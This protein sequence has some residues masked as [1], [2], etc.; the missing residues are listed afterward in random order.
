MN[1]HYLSQTNGFLSIL[2]FIRFGLSEANR[3][4]LY[5]GHGS[6][7][8][9]D[10]I[11]ALILGSL[12][13]DLDIDDRFL[14]ARLNKEEQKHLSKQLYQ[15]I[16]NRIPVAYLIH[17]SFFCGLPFYVDERVLI[18]RSPI[19]ELIEAEFSPWIKKEH[20]RRILDL[21]TGSG[22]IAIALAHQF[23][24]ASVLGSDLSA[25]ALMVAQKNKEAHLLDDKLTLIQSDC[26]QSI[27]K[28]QYDLIVSNPPYVSEDEFNDLPL[29]YTH[30][31]QLG[32]KAGDDGLSIV[33]IIL[34][35]AKSYL[36]PHGIL[37][38]EVGNAEEALINAFP[39]MP[40][41]WLEFERGGSGVFLLT[42]EDLDRNI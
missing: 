41:I 22:C 32:L 30:E 9:F 17:K 29:E 14:S 40:F 21:G 23:P 2:D 3:H 10:E 18:P 26:F 5:Y 38:V 27:P 8:A 16:Q 33:K 1:D 39:E 7:T 6:D 13:L 20:V 37:V 28:I 42:K 24:D 11:F 36:S 19:A 25:D 31:P 34:Q 12:D 35:E 4:N 15:R